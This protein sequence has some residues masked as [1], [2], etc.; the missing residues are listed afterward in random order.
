MA[1]KSIT[2]EFEDFGTRKIEI[3]S[4]K[5]I[6]K[7]KV[8]EPEIIINKPDKKKKSGGFATF[9]VFLLLIVFVGCAYYW[10]KEIY[11]D[12]SNGIEEKVNKK[13]GYSF[14]TYKSEKTLNLL[15][16]TYLLEFTDDVLYKVF[17]KK[18]KELFNDEIEYDQ[19]YMDLNDDLY[20][21]TD[22]NFET[23]N[24]LSLYK[25]E[26]GKFVLVNDYSQVGYTFNTLSLMKNDKYYLYGIIKVGSNFDEQVVTNSITLVE[27]EKEIKLDEGIFFGNVNDGL[28]VTNS[29]RYLPINNQEKVGLYDVIDNEKII[30]FNYDSLELVDG[31]DNR[32]VVKKDTKAALIDLKLKK[33]IDYKYEYIEYHKDYII[34]GKDHR[35]GVLNS[36]YKKLTDLVIDCNYDMNNTSLNSYKKGDN[37]IVT[38]D[39]NDVNNPYNTYFITKSGSVS[40][41]NE[42]YWDRDEFGYTVSSD[43]K[44]Y[45]IYDEN[46]IKKGVIDLKD[47]DFSNQ[48]SVS[49]IGDTYVL[50]DGIYFDKESLKQIDMI[51]E[52]K[53]DNES[54]GLSLNGD[55][56]V[57]VLIDDKSIGT[58]NYIYPYDLYNKMEDGTFYYLNENTYVTIKKVN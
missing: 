51:K 7:K 54:F 22:T 11:L 15:N 28:Y 2:D 16:D 1:K 27:N 21:L 5:E 13:L 25:L 39:F 37:L 52:F 44:L 57:S 32:L 53:V 12:D 4:P 38:V 6:K 49:L 35:I 19:I 30:D 8:K 58:Y 31:E 26:N 48:V 56:V 50:G 40:N 46:L 29:D 55:G 41:V 18:G 34:V 24:M 43:N 45:T 9:V 33:L 42:Q 14:V 23:G 47:Y 36:N 20:V 10:Y 17:D 3:I